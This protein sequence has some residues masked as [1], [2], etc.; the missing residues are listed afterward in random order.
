MIQF[1]RKQLSSTNADIPARPQHGTRNPLSRERLIARWFIRSAIGLKP[2]CREMPLRIADRLFQ[3]NR[4]LHIDE[5][6]G[7]HDAAAFN[8]C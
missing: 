3:S 4:V 5:A 2:D 1:R 7:R 6:R 8:A